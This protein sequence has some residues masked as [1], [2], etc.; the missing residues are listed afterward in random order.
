MLLV[1]LSKKTIISLVKEQYIS[2][3]ITSIYSQ[4]IIFQGRQKLDVG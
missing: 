4:A 2:K 3:I 1:F